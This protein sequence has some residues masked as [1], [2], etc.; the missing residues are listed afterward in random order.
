MP[1]STSSDIT[2]VT[3]GKN[4]KDFFTIPE[5]EQ[6]LESTPGS[7]KWVAKYFKVSFFSLL[8]FTVINVLRHRV[9]ERAPTPTPAST[10][11]GWRSI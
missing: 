2:Q 8:I 3:K 6:W 9:W 10:L 1:L 7:D 11:A 5:Y 4:R